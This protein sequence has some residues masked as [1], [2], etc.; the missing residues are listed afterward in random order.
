M[1]G[2]AGAE[3]LAREP[4]ELVDVGGAPK[5]QRTVGYIHVMARVEL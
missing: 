2:F 5:F 1:L 4:V 3:E